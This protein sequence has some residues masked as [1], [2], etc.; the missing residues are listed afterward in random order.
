M[1][2]NQEKRGWSG[3]KPRETGLERRKTKKIE[4]RAKENIKREVKAEENEEKR[5]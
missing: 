4:F 3:G 2:E 5:G 1:D